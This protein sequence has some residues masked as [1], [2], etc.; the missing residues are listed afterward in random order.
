[1]VHK[2]TM[3]GQTSIKMHIIKVIQTSFRLLK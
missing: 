2:N 3:L 1:M